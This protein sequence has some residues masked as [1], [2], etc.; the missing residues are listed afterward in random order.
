M[1]N[2]IFETVISEYEEKRAENKRE[3]DKRVAEVYGRVPEIREID[4]QINIVG[5]DTLKSILKEPDKTG[6]KEDMKNKFA[7]LSQKRRELLIQN[8]IDEDFDKI[9]YS[10]R[11]CMDTG[12]AEGK[13]R[14]AC[15]KQKLIDQLYKY[16]NMSA[17]LTKQNFETF[18]MKYYGK[19]I[20]E[21]MKISPYDNMINVKR[22][23]EKFAADFEKPS[24]SLI[25]YGDTGL[26]KTFLSS[27]MAKAVMDKGNTVLYLSATKLFSMFESNRFGRLKG[28]MDEVYESDL[29]IID[30]LGTEPSYKNGGAYLLELINDR[31]NRDKKII[32]NTNLNFMSLESRYSKR[33]TS[34]IMECFDMLYF[35]GEDIRRQKLF[36]KHKT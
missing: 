14:C 4:R 34:R 30:D 32:I 1:N 11:E 15:F 36:N 28:G 22:R 6:L 35:F 8:G 16:S 10:C 5:S 17:L 3:R 33:L 24:K 23:C 31:M 27:C 19:K 13:G 26:G 9:R 2:E 21:G 25:L 7:V 18:S 20:S 29:L 12:Y